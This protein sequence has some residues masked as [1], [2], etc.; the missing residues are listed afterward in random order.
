MLP[1]KTMPASTIGLLPVEEHERR[2]RRAT[3]AYPQL[4]RILDSV[5]DPE[6]PVISIW[7]LGVLQA[8]E[9]QGDAVVITITPTYSGCPAM[10]IIEEDISTA[11]IAAG[12]DRHRVERRLSPAWTTGWLS[13]AAREKLR[14][15]GIA[16]PAGV[17]NE[18]AIC[19]TC[20]QCG[21][22]AVR[23]ISEFGATA[24]KSLYQCDS[25]AEPFEHF[26]AI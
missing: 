6:I 20:P 21:S 10:D 11:L 25:C 5:M 23:C 24:C 15:Y 17:E 1:A 3:S 9:C 4:W 8:V 12:F 13:P 2:Q 14:L 26:K 19:V 7:E 18:G 22:D 16:P